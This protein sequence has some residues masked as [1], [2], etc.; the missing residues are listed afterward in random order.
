MPHKVQAHHLVLKGPLKTEGRDFQ[1]CGVDLA[2]VVTMNFMMEDGLR[3]ANPAGGGESVIFTATVTPAFNAGALTGG[4]TF[5]DGATALGTV[6]ISAGQAQFSTSSLSVGTHSI[7][8]GYAGDLNYLPSTSAAL[9]ETINSTATTTAVSS[10]S[11]PTTFGQPVTF[12]ATVTP[13]G[14]GTPTGTVVFSDGGSNSPA[15]CG[16]TRHRRSGDDPLTGCIA[17]V[18]G[19]LLAVAN[20]RGK[21]GVSHRSREE[22]VDDCRRQSW[23]FTSPA[24]STKWVARSRAGRSML[25]PT[26]H[27]ARISASSSRPS[28]LKVFNLRKGDGPVSS[29]DLPGTRLTRIFSSCPVISRFGLP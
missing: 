3:S 15:R 8:A 16:R 4:V 6:A 22:P 26:I 1:G 18:D 13:Q 5:Y 17:R 12:T 2:V 14:P 23:A 7:T 27:R 10:S 11:N 19:A 24:I 9:R 25:I 20:A 29:T 28:T 21:R